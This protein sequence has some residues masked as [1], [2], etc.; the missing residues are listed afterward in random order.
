MPVTT[1]WGSFEAVVDSGRLVRIEPRGDDPAPSPIGPGM[2]KAART[3][4]GYCVP[5]YAKG[6]STA[7]RAPVTPP[8]APTPSWRS[9]GTKRSHW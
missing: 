6:G 2:V 7:Y 1:H 8:E 3:A 4:R 9:A 5:R